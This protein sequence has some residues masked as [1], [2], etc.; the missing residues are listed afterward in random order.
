MLSSVDPRQCGSPISTPARVNP[1]ALLLRSRALIIAMLALGL[2]M[3]LPAVAT[4]A[5]IAPTNLVVTVD[6]NRVGA[7]SGETIVTTFSFCVPDG[8][9][10]G[11][12]FAMTMP[13]VLTHFPASLQIKDPN[14]VVYFDVT[15][16]ATT[17]A[18]ATF[19]MTAA[20][21]AAHNVCARAFMGADAGSAAVGDYPLGYTVGGQTVTPPNPVLTVFQPFSNAPQTTSK[22]GWFRENANQCRDTTAGCLIW[23]IWTRSGDHGI[24]T[25]TDT[26]GPNWTFDC[27]PF[28]SG[29]IRTYN[30]D[31][32]SS[33]QD[34]PLAN[35]IDVSCTA[36]TLTFGVDT[37]G[38][39]ANQSIQVTLRSSAVTPSGDGGVTYLNSLAVTTDGVATTASKAL[40]SA[41]AGGSAEGDSIIIY[42]RDAAGNDA[43]DAASAV[44]L[45]T[46]STGL[47]F[48][49]R[50]N[51]TTD[52]TSVD[53]SD[54]FTQGSPPATVTGLTCNF[55]E[56][57]VGAPTSGVTWAGP[58]HPNTQFTCTANLSGVSGYSTDV[59]KV[60]ATGNGPVSSTN[61]Y[62]AFTPPPV[63]SVGDF[64]WKD[65]DHDGVQDA[66]E[67]GIPGVVLTLKGPDGLPV[68]DVNGNPVGPVTTDANGAYTFANLPTLP[69]GQGYTVSI[70]VVASAAALT[71]LF[72]TL[73]GAGTV[74]TDS[75]TGSATSTID[76]SKSGAVDATLDFGFWA[77]APAITIVKMD[78]AGNDANTVGTAVLLTDGTASL[79]MVVTNTGNE[80]LANVVV[81]D[82]VVSGG[83]VRDLSCTFPDGSTG[84]SWA[85][86]LAVGAS[87]PCTASLVGVTASTTHEDVAT[88]T[89]I[90]AVSEAAVTH[91]DAYF[92]TAPAVAALASTGSDVARPLA[93]ALALILLGLVLMAGARRHL[94]QR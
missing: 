47:V 65:L 6:K 76:L 18:V 24:I 2:T 8:G 63:V 61:P 60:T 79:A 94:T 73:T 67:P 52:L 10:A 89:G 70:D 49:I 86:P 48:Q 16:S 85:G 54:A 88:V 5:T 26:A 74:A 35:L 59:A 56:A 15:I 75:S 64:V 72:P 27:M 25:I 46:G 40:Q 29:R 13:A 51:G 84:V 30:A 37:T 92:A 78:S 68:T 80:P 77:A 38:L 93:A 81:S 11:D 43:N 31:G 44:T 45:P 4:A 91:S 23:H 39:A 12:S 34:Y 53:V 71:G 87:F 33:Y 32:T 90:G 7:G 19:T 62:V 3:V 69:A 50:N 22:N 36:G 20:A 82:S 42:K 83:E 14:G 21:A 58:F 66:G 17:P 55:S 28:L 9:A 57:T 1:A 41:Y